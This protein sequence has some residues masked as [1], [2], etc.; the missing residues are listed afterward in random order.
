[1]ALERR[2][3]YREFNDF[4]SSGEA[5]NRGI[6]KRICP[7]LARPFC[8]VWERSKNLFSSGV[9]L[10]GSAVAVGLW[11]PKKSF[12]SVMMAF[13]FLLDLFYLLGAVC[14]TLVCRRFDTPL[15]S[16]FCGNSSS[17]LS[18]L[19]PS[20]PEEALQGVELHV[21][22][23]LV[24]N[25]ALLSSHVAFFWC[26]W[27]LGNRSVYC[28]TMEKAYSVATHSNWVTLNVSKFTFGILFLSIYFGLPR[29][30]KKNSLLPII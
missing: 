8:R 25:F 23:S 27:K 5:N 24:R 19:R 6:S 22:L 29:R 13:V 16:W 18:S 9:F 20:S 1:M 17:N 4:L 12:R 26:M 28:V 15:N 3:Q 14:Y 7:P 10:K 21:F 30:W 2:P 11:K